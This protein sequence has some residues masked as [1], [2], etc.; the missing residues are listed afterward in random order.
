MMRDTG[1]DFYRFDQYCENIFARGFE[2]NMDLGNKYELIT[3]F[4]VFEHLVNP[5]DHVKQIL[6]YS[7]NVLFSTVL[8]PAHLPK[9]DEWWYYGLEHG[10]HVSLYTKKTLQFI[11]SAFR[12][13]LYLGENNIFLLTKR[14]VP[15]LLFRLATNYKFS[16]LYNA[17]LGFRKKTLLLDDYYKASGRKLI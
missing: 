14:R 3:A 16:F 10:Q 8:M 12:L 7:D 15:F 2:A 13:N 5:L 4:E 9:P 6:K 1:F 11:A 17:V